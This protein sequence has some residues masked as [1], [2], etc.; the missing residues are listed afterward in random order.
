MK[1]NTLQT[2]VDLYW[3]SDCPSA[4]KI[5]HLRKCA[6][7]TDE[8]TILELVTDFYS[9]FAADKIVEECDISSTTNSSE[10]D[11]IVPDQLKVQRGRKRACGVRKQIPNRKSE[12]KENIIAVNR[13]AFLDFCE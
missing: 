7:K 12:W 1:C 4:S 13:P 9:D 8:S 3:K 5:Y 2:K 6:K 11:K 10:K